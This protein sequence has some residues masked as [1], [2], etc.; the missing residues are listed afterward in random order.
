MH[1]VYYED[2]EL[3]H[4]KVRPLLDQKPVLYAQM[5]II[6]QSVLKSSQAYGEHKPYGLVVEDVHGQVLG[7]A[8]RI[9][10]QT[11]GCA[12]IPGKL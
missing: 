9:C 8:L 12:Q 5:R 1:V 2:F 10:S 4:E 6:I 11:R 7:A 3:F